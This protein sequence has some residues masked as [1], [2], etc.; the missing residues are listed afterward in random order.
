MQF[1]IDTEVELRHPRPGGFPPSGIWGYRIANVAF[2]GL[3]YF[4]FSKIAGK[5]AKLLNKGGSR[6]QR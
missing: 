5:A 6:K 2:N 3:N 1:F 4:W